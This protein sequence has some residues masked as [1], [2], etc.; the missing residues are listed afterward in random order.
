[1]RGIKGTVKAI[2]DPCAMCANPLTE[3]SIVYRSNR[4]GALSYCR[5]CM[6]RRGRQAD[7]SKRNAASRKHA[8]KI[9]QQVIEAYGGACSCCGETTYEFLA[10]DHVNGG[11]SQHRKSVTSPLELCRLIVREGFPDAYQL[12]CHNCNCAKGWYGACPHEANQGRGMNAASGRI[13]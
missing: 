7:K 11:G 8:R 3:S 4:P 9:R 13:V 1:M 5:P 10:I 6:N 2:G 12:L